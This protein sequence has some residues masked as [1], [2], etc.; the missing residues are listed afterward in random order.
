MKSIDK[1]SPAA[2]Q[3]PNKTEISNE[4]YALAEAISELTAAIIM[5]A[6]RPN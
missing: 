1:Y 5:L 2:K 4:A 6:R 3:E